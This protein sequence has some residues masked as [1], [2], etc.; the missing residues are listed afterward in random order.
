MKTSQGQK[1]NQQT[2]PTDDAESGNQTLVSLVGSECSCHCAATALK[3]N[4]VIMW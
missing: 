2:Q 1:E 4:G 3:S